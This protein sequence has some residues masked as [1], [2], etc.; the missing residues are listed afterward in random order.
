LDEE[1]IE[2]YD[3]EH[4]IYE[5]R[6]IV[7]GRVDKVLTIVYTERKDRIRIISARV[8]TK[9]EEELYYDRT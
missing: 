7:V 1:R 2:L 5:D 9:E 4:S 6:Y 3:F 8:A